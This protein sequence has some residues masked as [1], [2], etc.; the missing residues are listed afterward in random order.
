MSKKM[1]KS[2]KAKR[3]DAM[4]KLDQASV[5]ANHNVPMMGGIRGYDVGGFWPMALMMGA[6]VRRNKGRKA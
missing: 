5:V 6:M 1:S 3:K 4:I 2:E